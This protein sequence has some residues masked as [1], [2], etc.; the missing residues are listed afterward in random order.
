[1]K[2]SIKFHHKKLD[3]KATYLV[4]M[5]EHLACG[6]VPRWRRCSN[7]RKVGQQTLVLQSTPI[8]FKQTEMN[9]CST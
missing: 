2:Q 8:P 9:R 3:E 5:A 7:I 4:K 6:A 1:M